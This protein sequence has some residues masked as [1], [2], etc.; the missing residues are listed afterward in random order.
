LHNNFAESFVTRGLS[1][2]P[3]CVLDKK[4]LIP[5]FFQEI[6]DKPKMLLEIPETSLKENVFLL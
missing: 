2:L 3:V 4:K 1:P 6:K 5:E